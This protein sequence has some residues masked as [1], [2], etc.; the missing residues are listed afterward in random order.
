M[1]LS[2]LVLFIL[3]RIGIETY[4]TCTQEYVLTGRPRGVGETPLGVNPA[5]H[6]EE[7]VLALRAAPEIADDELDT[8]LEIGELFKRMVLLMI[9]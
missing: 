5:Y 9:L 7:D 8:Q 2:L 4:N 6:L 1:F 3:N